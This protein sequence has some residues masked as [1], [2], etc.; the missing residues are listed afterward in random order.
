MRKQ[1]L[2]RRGTPRELEPHGAPPRETN[3]VN[4]DLDRLGLGALVDSQFEYTIGVGRAD[5]VSAR[6]ERKPEC[7]SEMTVA[8][9]CDMN[10]C[11]LRPLGPLALRCNTQLIVLHLHVEGLALEPR[12]LEVEMVGVLVLDHIRPGLH[13]ATRGFVHIALKG[14]QLS[15]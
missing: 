4:C 11:L 3:L 2:P 10:C 8:P 6:V 5:A 1:G 13:R 14:G 9:L 12:H 7:A 15:D